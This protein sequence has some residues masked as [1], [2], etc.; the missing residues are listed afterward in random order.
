MLVHGSVARGDAD[1]V[2]WDI[3]AGHRLKSV[4]LVNYLSDDKI[5]FY[6]LQRAS[7]FDAGTDVN[8]MLVYGH[9]GPQDLSRNVITATPIEQLGTGAMTLWFQ[10]TG[11]QA[12]HY[13]LEVT[14][15]LIN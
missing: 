7:V 8:R 9:M 11:Q 2:R 5:A 6:A 3:S 1:Y 10:Q 15:Q 13:A 14:L 12:T 4:K